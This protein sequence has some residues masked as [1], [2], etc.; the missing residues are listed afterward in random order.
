MHITQKVRNIHLLVFNYLLD[1][2]NIRVYMLP[3]PVSV[4]HLQ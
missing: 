2:Y 3:L 1:K 4:D